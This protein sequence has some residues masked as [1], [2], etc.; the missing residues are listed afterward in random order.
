[1]WRT[2]GNHVNWQIGWCLPAFPVERRVISN[3]VRTEVSSNVIGIDPPF[4]L[5]W[6]KPRK[7]GDRRNVPSSFDGAAA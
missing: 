1:M 5:I 6:K 4:Q 7:P 3:G 2:G